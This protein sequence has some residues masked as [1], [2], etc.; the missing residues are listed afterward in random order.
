[1]SPCA[2]PALLVPKKDG[3]WRMC[4]DSRVVNKITI[5]YCFLIP[6]FDDLIDQLHG[7]T[8]FS[9]INLRSGYHQIRVRPGDEWKMAFKTH[10][11]LY[12]WMVMP[13]GLQRPKHLHAVNESWR[14]FSWTREAEEAFGLLKRKVTEALVLI[15]PDFDEVFE[16]HC[17]ASGVGIGGVLSQRSRL[18]AFFSEKL[19]ETRCKYSTYDKEFYAITYS[20]SIKHKAVALNKVADALSRRQML[21][22]TMQV[23]EGD[24]V[25]IRLG[26]ERFPTGR[27]GILQPRADGPFCVLKRINDNAY[28]ID[29]PGEYHVSTTFNVADLSPYVTD[30]EDS[31]VEEADV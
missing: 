1:M 10:D 3:S 11:G 4:I 7:A 12:E 6:R 15:L 21:L 31:K 5:K 30:E 17:D 23:Q 14:K 26:K 13:F 9:K 18:I 8:I 16:V 28:K 20:F 29:L 27:F 22:S 19:N 25:W 24:M 2:V